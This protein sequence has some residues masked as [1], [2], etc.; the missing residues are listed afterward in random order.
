VDGWVRFQHNN[1]IGYI[2]VVW[3]NYI[4]V[5][6]MLEV[7]MNCECNLPKVNAN[8]HMYSESSSDESNG[9]DYEIVGDKPI[10]NNENNSNECPVCYDSLG[11][12]AFCTLNCKHKV[13]LQC[14]MLMVKKEECPYCR[15]LVS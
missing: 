1:K 7:D 11:D 6:K 14:Y 5:E 4:M 15:G 12:K 9:I 8:G 3:N 10:L 2:K 13:C